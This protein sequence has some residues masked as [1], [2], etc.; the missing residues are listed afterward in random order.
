MRG[1]RGSEHDGRGLCREVRAQGRVMGCVEEGEVMRVLKRLRALKSGREKDGN[2]GEKEMEGREIRERGREG[3]GEVKV[4][5]RYQEEGE[6]V[7]G[8]GNMC[9]DGREIREKAKE[10]RGMCR[11][12]RGRRERM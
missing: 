10:G 9:G 11:W 2:E 8:K 12:K 4:C 7:N 6:I 5:C 1:Q 3:R